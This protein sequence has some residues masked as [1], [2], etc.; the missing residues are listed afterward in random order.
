LRP[1]SAGR[2]EGSKKVVG[3]EMRAGELKAGL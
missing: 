1:S 3:S 2:E